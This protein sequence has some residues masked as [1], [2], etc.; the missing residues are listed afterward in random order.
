MPFSRSLL[1]ILLTTLVVSGSGLMGTLYYMHIREL[2]LQDKQYHIVALVQNCLQS[3]PL[4]TSY[5][6]QLLGLSLDKPVNLYQFDTQ[7]GEQKLLTCPLIK[8]ASIQKIRPG[9]LYIKYQVRVPIAHLGDYS[10][11]A[12]DSEGYLIPF[13]PF[14][15]PKRLPVLFLGVEGVWGKKLEQDRLDLA[16]YFLKKLEGLDQGFTYVKQVDISN[17][18]AD[19]YGQRQ[20]VVLLT[21]MVNNKSYFLRLNPNE[22]SQNLKDFLLLKSKMN[23]NPKSQ[24]IID[25]RIPQLAFIKEAA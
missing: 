6:A 2:R 16:L 19:S 10:N 17:A 14:F 4:K 1:W 7:E 12:I 24:T 13:Q 21:S 23:F 11:T 15:T 3:E 22:Y 25:F 5:L 20:I 9:A 18:F 8:E